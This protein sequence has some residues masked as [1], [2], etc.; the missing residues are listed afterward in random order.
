MAT[1]KLGIM[2]KS[3]KDAY[4][5]MTTQGNE[6]LPQ[7]KLS[8]YYATGVIEETAKV[9]AAMNNSIRIVH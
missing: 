7:I 1:A 3:K 6:Y 8:N 9:S 2:S 5:L 4:H